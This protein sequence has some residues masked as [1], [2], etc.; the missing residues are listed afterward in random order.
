MISGKTTHWYEH[1]A[2]NVSGWV[3]GSLFF[4]LVQF[5]LMYIVFAGA[6]WLFIAATI[7]GSNTK[8]KKRELRQKVTTLT[9]VLTLG[10][11]MVVNV[12]LATYLVLR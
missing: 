12:I 3:C 1:K 4:L 6:F 2:L 10:M 8:E 11:T 7:F 9:A 5:N